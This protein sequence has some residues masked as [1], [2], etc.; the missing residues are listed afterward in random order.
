MG[1][2]HLRH[3]ERDHTVSPTKNDSI[4]VSFI[5]PSVDTRH[6]RNRVELIRSHV[7]GRRCPLRPPPPAP[8][9]T[10]HSAQQRCLTPAV[11]Q[12]PSTIQEQEGQPAPATIVNNRCPCLSSGGRKPIV[13][14]VSMD[15][16]NAATTPTGT[17]T[18]GRAGA[19]AG[20]CREPG[21]DR[22]TTQVSSSAGAP[23][24]SFFPLLPFFIFLPLPVYGPVL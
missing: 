2:V 16:S 22:T 12:V 8:D 4:N 19:G 1:A 9:S 15:D 3:A 14:I 20:G 11:V 7:S 10:L 21:T 5:S 24:P 18:G 23:R 6:S 13:S 17:G